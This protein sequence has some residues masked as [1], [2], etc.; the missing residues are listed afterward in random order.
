MLPDY[1]DIRRRLG[2]PLWFDDHG[3]PRYD[4]FH[5][6]MCDVYADYVALLEIECVGCKQHFLVSAALS[7]GKHYMRQ[8]LENIPAEQVREIV[9][10]SA[11]SSGDFDFGDAPRHS[12]QWICIGEVAS[13]N[14]VAVREFWRRDLEDV[15]DWQ[16]DPG[17][18]FVYGGD[19]K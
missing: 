15:L 1:S 12:T 3:V 4:E 14:I 10:P 9:L 16:R 17:H 5:P 8:A 6:N 7:K 19:A 18:E 11:E 13:C 2:E